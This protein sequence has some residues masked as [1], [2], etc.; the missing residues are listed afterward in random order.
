MSH[1]L[2]HWL[3]RLIGFEPGPGEGAAWRLDGNWPLAPWLTLVLLALVV[4]VVLV[5]CVKVR[6]VCTARQR[7]LLVFLRLAAIGLLLAM[8]GGW[9]ITI[10]RT[11][12]PLLAVVLDDSQSMTL[13]DRMESA[14]Q[15]LAKRRVADAGFGEVSRWNQA[16]AWLLEDH[17]ALLHRLADRYQLRFYSVSRGEAL[18]GTTPQALAESLVAMSATG[19]RTRLG[20][21]ILRVLDKGRGNPPAAIVLL[22][23]GV[24]TDGPSLAA[25]A[26]AARRQGVPVFAVGLGDPRPP[27]E[28][29]I[30]ELVYD[31]LVFAGEPVRFR[32]RLAATGCAGQ[33]VEVV[34]REAKPNTVVASLTTRAPAERSEP[35]QLE[36]RPGA[37]GRH[38]YVLEVV[39]SEGNRSPE[40]K[41]LAASVEV[42]DE[43]IRVLLADGY[44]RYEFRYLKNLLGR[45]ASIELHSV[46]QSADAEHTR[47]DRAALEAF[48]THIDELLAYDVV[49][50]GDLGPDWLTPEVLANLRDFVARKGKGG[51]LVLIAGR[52]FMPVAYRDTLLAALSPVEL[53]SL[54]WPESP[55]DGFAL[56]PTP[57]GYANPGLQLGD[58]AAENSEVWTHLPPV[59]NL[60]EAGELKAG[61][62]S[63]VETST[64]RNA[65]GHPLPAVVLQYY[66]AGRVLMHLTDETWR[67]RW[68]AGDEWFGRYWLQT[69]RWLARAKLAGRD[70]VELTAD[71]AQYQ[72]EQTVQL[73]LRF[74]DPRNAPAADD[75][76]TV[77]VQHEGMRTEQVRLARAASLRGQFEGRYHPSAAGRYHA[78]L[79]APPVEGQ[80]PAVDFRVA[81]PG[82]EFDR[83]QLDVAALEE[84]ARQT[85]GKFYTLAAAG[86]LAGEL[87]AGE[88]VT[89]EALPPRPLWNRWPVLALLIGLL[90]LEWW[91]RNRYGMA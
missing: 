76:V 8:I 35:L 49:L 4:A 82:S 54:R 14:E 43:R 26:A 84:A 12:L 72:A 73:T 68:R 79:V 74:S 42:R 38:D 80:A 2:P 6:G 57:L 62:K 67:W 81:P 19:E 46:L 18:P 28:L 64:A 71:R 91:L 87:P 77:L 37:V 50:L 17:V 69:I 5:G 86:R 1:T 33:K 16:R 45:E 10:Q 21:C 40:G 83:T 15:E 55:A 22:T 34:L 85:R 11:G 47:Q 7:T 53:G 9:T 32:F 41:R 52:R 25:A 44:P 61:A 30:E 66:G 56:R 90:T 24:N 36:V 78:W 13:T 75:A 89:L 65:E 3:A 27:R 70:D 29:R 63:L 60:L 58:S 20:A 48:P 39:A 51:A 88:Q 23:D 31:D 59:R